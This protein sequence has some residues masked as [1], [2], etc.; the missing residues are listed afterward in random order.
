MCNKDCLTSLHSCRESHISCEG[1]VQRHWK[2]SEQDGAEEGDDIYVLMSSD[3]RR[4]MEII[5]VWLQAS[6]VEMCTLGTGFAGK[7]F[8]L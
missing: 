4:L 7:L 8:E 2:C 5:H 1:F 6:F 3:V